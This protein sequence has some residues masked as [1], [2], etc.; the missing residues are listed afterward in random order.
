MVHRRREQLYGLEQRPGPP[1]VVPL[2]HFAYG[3]AER[4]VL[5]P[6]L[7]LAPPNLF[8][9]SHARTSTEPKRGEWQGGGWALQRGH[10]TCGGAKSPSATPQAQDAAAAVAATVERGEVHGPPPPRHR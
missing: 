5:L 7:L 1:V 2:E 10:R 8:F 9:L 6:A 4:Q 3:A